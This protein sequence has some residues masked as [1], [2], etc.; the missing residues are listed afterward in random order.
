MGAVKP[1]DFSPVD[2]M[3]HSTAHVLAAAVQELYPEAK[4]GVGPVIENGFYYDIELPASVTPQ[5]LNK[6]EKRMRRIVERNEEF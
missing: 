6:I 5:D 1:T 2:E 4:F 3:R